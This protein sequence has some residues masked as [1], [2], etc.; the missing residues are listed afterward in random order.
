MST[1]SPIS[2]V[3]AFITLSN[4][5]PDVAEHLNFNQ[6]SLFIQIIATLKSQ[7]TSATE[8]SNHPPSSIQRR[9][10][11][12]FK[13]IFGWNKRQAKVCWTVFKELGWAY[14]GAVDIR[15][16]HPLI[17]QH[18]LKHDIGAFFFLLMLNFKCL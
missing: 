3:S 13:A 2:A 8:P 1:S 10:H 9:F 18:G 16:V 14:D 17:V 12:L 4:R 11:Y 15:R 7:I 6:I 5:F